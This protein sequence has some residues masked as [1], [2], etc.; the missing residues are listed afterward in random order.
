MKD[1]LVTLE[2]AKLAKD[3]GFN[4]N[5]YFYFN[6]NGKIQHNYEFYDFIDYNNCG[7]IS[8]PN[9]SLLQ[10][11]LRY[12]NIIVLVTYDRIENITGDYLLP[13]NCIIITNNDKTTIKGRFKNYEDALE[14]GLY[15]A[16][17]LL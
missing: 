17:K 9:Q 14:K 3:K 7:Y 4:L 12:Y 1:D 6:N 16:L 5:C 10:K 2:T 11:Y 15:E 8:A 13:Y